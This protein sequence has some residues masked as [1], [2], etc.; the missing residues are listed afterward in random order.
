MASQPGFAFPQPLSERYARQVL[1]QAEL[2]ILRDVDFWKADAAN[3]NIVQDTLRS[4]RTDTVDVL[5]VV[6]VPAEQTKVRRKSKLD[7]HSVPMTAAYAVLSVVTPG[8][9]ASVP[10]RVVDGQKLL[11]L[12]T[13]A[14]AEISIVSKDRSF[15]AGRLFTLP[16]EPVRRT[17]PIG[18]VSV[19]PSLDLAGVAE[20]LP[21]L[22]STLNTD[23]GSTAGLAPR[24]LCNLLFVGKHDRV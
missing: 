7:D 2:C 17:L 11:R 15:V 14:H 23:S 20:T 5:S 19:R 4:M 16:V 24:P 8:V 12:L 13:T 10:L 3:W 9:F 6:T 21:A 1:K 18:S 22:G